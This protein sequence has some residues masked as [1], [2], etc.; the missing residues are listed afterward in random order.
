MT[1]DMTD[2]E[3]LR[4]VARG[5]EHA[6]EQLYARHAR[7]LLAYAEGLL[8]EREPAEEALQET[9]IAVWRGADAFEGRSQVRTWLFGVCRRQAL[10]R[11]RGHERPRPID[12]V[13]DLPSPEPGPQA[14]ALARADAAAVAAALRTLAPL[15]R[16]VLDLAFAA[17]MSHAEIAEVLGVPPGT[18]KSR[19]FNARAALARALPVEVEEAGR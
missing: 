10:K 18:V 7:A 14:V 13:V 16:E 6:F 9:F 4:L 3:L 11:M 17:G 15:H 1:M 8:G 19:L 2:L 5:D 12:D